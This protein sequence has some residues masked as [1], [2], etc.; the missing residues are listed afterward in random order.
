MVFSVYGNDC[1]PLALTQI[2]P[3]KETAYHTG[4]FHMKT[5]D[6]V[7]FTPGQLVKII[8]SWEDAGVR[9]DGVH[10][11]LS[12][13][14]LADLGEYMASHKSLP[15]TDRGEF[16]EVLGLDP[17]SFQV[18]VK[19]DDGFDG[20][21]SKAGLTKIDPAI[22]QGQFREVGRR[23]DFTFQMRIL[24][25][26]D[27]SKLKNTASPDC[28]VETLINALDSWLRKEKMRFARFAE[29]VA[30]T[31]YYRVLRNTAPLVA[32][33][34]VSR[35]S[36]KKVAYLTRGAHEGNV[37]LLLKPFGEVWREALKPVQTFRL[38]AVK[39]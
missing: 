2:R 35:D 24:P 39:F 7:T 22:A 25:L 11:G 30:F 33:G 15:L 32:L 19:S 6:N 12:Q 36:H 38:L 31:P 10:A 37:S 20:L 26:P 28:L 8:Q 3:S 14:L 13:G 29:L 27:A 23:F 4:V 34:D 9:S 1:F 5:A 21:I 16:R 18:D 17:L